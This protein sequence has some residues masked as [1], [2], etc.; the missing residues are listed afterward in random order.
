MPLFK[1]IITIT[2]SSTLLLVGTLSAHTL[3]VT[4]KSKAAA[5][6]PVTIDQN[7]KNGDATVNTTSNRNP[8][9]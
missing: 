4:K 7:Q 2:L 5:T 1:K 3:I 6:Q 8:L 9:A